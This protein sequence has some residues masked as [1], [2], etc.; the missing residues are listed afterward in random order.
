MNIKIRL[1]FVLIVAAK[2]IEIR[3]ADSNLLYGVSFINFNT[4]QI[5][6]KYTTNAMHPQEE[7]IALK[8]PKY[9]PN[10]GSVRSVIQGLMFVFSTEILS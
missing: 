9:V 3:R 1:Q 5:F 7:T 10:S 6:P 2:M 8:N 4:L